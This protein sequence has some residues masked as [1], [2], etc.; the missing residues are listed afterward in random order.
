MDKWIR[1]RIRPER[2][3]VH[4][5]CCVHNCN[6]KV[7]CSPPCLFL[8]RFVK[9]C[10]RPRALSYLFIIH[11]EIDERNARHE[12]T[13]N[14][15]RANIRRKEKERR[16]NVLRYSEISKIILLWDEE[17]LMCPSK[18]WATCLQKKARKQ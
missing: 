13:I 16:S 4:S 1:I 15:I 8:I 6:N 7:R 10:T 12:S 3:A 14:N 17:V 11:G 9:Y 18:V 2:G 5:I